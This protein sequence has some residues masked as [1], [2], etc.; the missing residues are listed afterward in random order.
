MLIQMYSLYYFNIPWNL[1][2]E[3]LRWQ[4]LRKWKSLSLVQ[5]FVTPW[6]LAQQAPLSMEFSRQEYWNGLPFPSPADLPNPGIELPSPADSLLSESPGEL[7]FKDKIPHLKS[8][9][10]Q[11]GKGIYICFSFR[12]S[13]QFS[14][15]ICRGCLGRHDRGL[16][17]W[18][19][20]GVRFH[21]VH[22]CYVCVSVSV[23][24]E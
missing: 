21:S 6:T 4:R 7:S 17:V 24:E 10:F 1:F 22:V 11:E 18:K 8:L 20:Q 23:F 12:I 14:W 19:G 16:S 3:N 9:G 2:L 5:L 13:R 15:F